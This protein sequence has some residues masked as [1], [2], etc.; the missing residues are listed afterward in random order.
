MT[1]EKK[2][3]KLFLDDYRQPNVCATYMHLRIGA[4]NPIYLEDWEVVVN[5]PEFVKFVTEHAGELEYVSFD[6]DLADAHYTTMQE[7]DLDY[8]AETADREKTGWHCAKFL[9]DH[10]KEK[11]LKLPKVIVHSMNPVG[12]DNII[13]LFEKA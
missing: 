10:Y 1:E 13:S 2:G 12:T 6:H 3:I 4:L 5:Y 7:G 11:N 8:E 9:I